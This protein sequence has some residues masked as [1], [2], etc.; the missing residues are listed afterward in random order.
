MKQAGSI[1]TSLNAFLFSP[2]GFIIYQGNLTKI[3]PANA[4]PITLPLHFGMINYTPS[5]YSKTFSFITIVKI[6][7]TADN[8]NR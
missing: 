1:R 2:N 7:A 5:Y 4:L 6:P 8:A 3:A